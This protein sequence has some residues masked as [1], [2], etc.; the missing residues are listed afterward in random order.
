MTSGGGEQVAEKPDDTSE[1]DEPQAPTAAPL[2][3]DDDD[4]A[5]G[6][7]VDELE[8]EGKEDE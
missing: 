5:E 1:V 7:G 6:V 8:A 4:Q 3:D 2:A